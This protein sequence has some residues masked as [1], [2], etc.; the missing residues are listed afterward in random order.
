MLKKTYEDVIASPTITEQEAVDLYRS[1]MDEVSK[2]ILSDPKGEAWVPAVVIGVGAPQSFMT[3]DAQGKL[4]RLY[5]AAS[6]IPYDFDIAWSWDN[7]LPIYTQWI[8]EVRDGA[9][10]KYLSA[11]EESGRIM[12]EACIEAGISKNY[13]LPFMSNWFG[14]KRA[15]N[16]KQQDL[17]G[18]AVEVRYIKKAP[19]RR[20]E[21]DAI[22]PVT[23][24]ASNV[25]DLLP[26]GHR[27]SMQEGCHESGLV[28]A[29]RFEFPTPTYKSY[30]N[31]ISCV[32]G[33]N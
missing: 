5:F 24:D 8:G 27:E 17:V 20:P 4:Q 25:A 29:F 16:N 33:V 32:E 22:R 2:M 3:S 31:Y 15:F 18:A 23:V 30:C 21:I 14:A 13:W 6:P 1:K 19:N 28:Q 10:E 11:I 9:D 7:T 26:Y 12:R